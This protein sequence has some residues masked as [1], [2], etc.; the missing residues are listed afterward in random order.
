MKVLEACHK[1]GK[2]AGILAMS[3]EQAVQR[4]RQGFLMVGLGID[5]DSI[6]TMAKD[7][8]QKMRKELNS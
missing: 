6:F 1:A 3:P 8:I 7:G 2:P 4:V 5:V